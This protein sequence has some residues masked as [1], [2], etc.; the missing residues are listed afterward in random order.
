MKL[1]D[2]EKCTDVTVLL[3]VVSMQDFLAWDRETSGMPKGAA[4]ARTRANAARSRIESL[5]Q[6][7]RD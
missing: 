6:K 5:N 1:A 2:I 3:E 7:E 4:V